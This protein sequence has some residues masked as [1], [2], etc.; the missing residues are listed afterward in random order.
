MFSTLHR[1]KFN[2]SVTFI[3][4]SASAFNLDQCKI[5]SFGKEFNQFSVTLQSM[6]KLWTV[7]Y[8]RAEPHS[9]VGSVADLR[10]G[11]C[12]FD[13]RTGQYPFRGLMI[14]IATGFIPLSPLSVVSTVN[15]VALKEYCA[16]Y[17]LKEI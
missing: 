2:F 6:R 17:W 1:T 3:V 8:E 13:P 10:T 4:S 7:P 5:L 12:W 11:G 16:E 15:A 14:V 9:S